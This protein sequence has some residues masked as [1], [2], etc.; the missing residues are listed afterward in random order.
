MEDFLWM[1]LGVVIA[2]VLPALTRF[3]KSTFG[4][5]AAGAPTWVAQY[6][7][8]GAFALVTALLLLAGYKAANPDT[9]LSWFTA[10]LAG[11]GWE[12]GLEKLR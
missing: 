2:I 1:A 8:L 10:L 3:V 9:E 12:S 5:T 7:A 11:F 4:V 6:A